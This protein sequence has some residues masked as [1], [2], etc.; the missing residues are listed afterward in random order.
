VEWVTLG[1]GLLGI[2]LAI[3]IPLRV[4][5]ERRP[6]LRIERGEDLNAT[7]LPYSMPSYRI[8]H[9]KVYNEPISGWPAR[10]LLRNTATGC[11]V[12]LRLRSRSDGSATPWWRG[13]WS[14]RPEPIQTLTVTLRDGREILQQFWDPQ[15]EPAMFTY[16][17]PSG[18][19]GEGVAVAIK[20]DGDTEAYAYAA[21]VYRHLPGPLKDAGLALRDTEYDVTVRATAGEIVEEETFFLRN[22]GLHY[23]GL[24]FHA[25]TAE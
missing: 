10:W 22:E 12:K 7:N 8:V 24:S 3:F 20:H 18:E 6:R 25:A 9:V 15:K 16:D 2:A 13:K 19:D 17:L 1:L 4:E 23:T 5:Y 21:S 11:H 14:A